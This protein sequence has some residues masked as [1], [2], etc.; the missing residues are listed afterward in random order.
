MDAAGQWLDQHCGARVVRY[1]VR[2]TGTEWNAR[3][4]PG[5]NE[6][7]RIEIR[8]YACEAG[9]EIPPASGGTVSP[10]PGNPR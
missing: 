5:N 4:F 2:D 9:A 7:W 1:L 6:P 10:K 8:Q 3:L